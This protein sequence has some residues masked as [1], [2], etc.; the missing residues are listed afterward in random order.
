M[1][2]KQE[3]TDKHFSPHQ[4]EK[5]LF[6]AF[7]GHSL[8][9]LTEMGDFDRLEF[10]LSQMSEPLGHPVGSLLE[11]VCSGTTAVE[12]LVVIKAEAK[13]FVSTANT[14]AQKAAATMLYHL[15]IASAL[16]NYG[17]FISSKDLSEALTLYARLADDLLDEELA[18]VFR[19]AVSR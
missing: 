17:R 14:P 3:S 13:R 16:G 12:T 6:L 7:S 18:R 19:R 10:L 9:D 11:A 4:A 5:L 8:I 2:Y 15:A 1:P